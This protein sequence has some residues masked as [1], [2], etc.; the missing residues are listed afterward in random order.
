M[1]QEKSQPYRPLVLTSIADVRKWRLSCTLANKTVGLV[2]TMGALHQ[3]H[4]SLI[5]QSLKNNGATII[6]IFVNPSQFAPNED[7]DAYPRTVEDDI[8]LVSQLSDT[9]AGL[10]T[11]VDVVFLPNVKEMYPSGIPLD[12]SQQSGAFVSVL[13]LS[14]MLEGKTRPNFF[15]GV[16][17]V[18]SKFFIIV[19]PTR[20]YFGQKDYQQSLVIRRMVKDLLFDIEIV[21]CDIYRDDSGL[22]LSSRNK[23]LDGPTVEM[24]TNIYRM[25]KHGKDLYEQQNITSVA[26]LQKQM[27][28]VIQPFVDDGAMKVDYISINDKDTLE[29]LTEIDTNKGGCIT[30]AIYVTN[31]SDD[32]VTRL[33]DN[34]LL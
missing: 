16:A 20:A 22:A 24:S 27:M 18:V 3:G 1:E 5:K 32:N 21:V 28:A 33:I 4:L 8:S 23:Y 15:R 31:S 25:L 34:I 30:C 17:T 29:E 10:E 13:G 2:P 11:K 19:T 9:H 7:L 26:E 14:E 6:S 12:V